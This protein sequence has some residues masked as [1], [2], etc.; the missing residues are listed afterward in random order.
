MTDIKEALDRLFQYKRTATPIQAWA[1]EQVYKTSG[2][3]LNKRVEDKDSGFYGIIP[4]RG[5]F[6]NKR[7]T[8][9]AVY[10]GEKELSMEGENTLPPPFQNYKD[11]S[12][13][14]MGVLLQCLYYMDGNVN[15]IACVK[16]WTNEII[17]FTPRRNVAEAFLSQ[18]QPIVKFEETKK[19]GKAAA[20]D[21]NQ[22]RLF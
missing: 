11:C 1:A 2:E 6:D 18:L 10:S 12:Y 14:H 9:I 17:Y 22:E 7:G 16:N 4:I 3:N 19:R 15:A 13:V 20:F 8:T 21:K 5:V